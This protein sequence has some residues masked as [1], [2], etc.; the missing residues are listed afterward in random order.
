MNAKL[1]Q[2]NATH[3]LHH[4]TLA[5]LTQ[6][7]RWHLT[8]K[9]SCP[10][11]LGVLLVAISL[12]SYGSSRL[13]TFG[14]FGSDGGVRYVDNGKR[15][16]FVIAAR[17]SAR[18]PLLDM[19]L[20]NI[21]RWYGDTEA[22]IVI[23]DNHYINVTA[24]VNST[25]LVQQAVAA[26][27]LPAT[28]VHIVTNLDSN[29]WGYEFG[30]MRAVGRALR[31][32]SLASDAAEV[33]SDLVQQTIPYDFIIVMQHTMAL[34]APLDFRQAPASNIPTRGMP[35][36]RLDDR[37]SGVATGQPFR[38]FMDFP[39]NSYDNNEERRYALDM[40]TAITGRTELSVCPGVF[41]PNWLMSG[42]CAARFAA[43]GVFEKAKVT[44][45]LQQCASERLLPQLAQFLCGLPC[46]V[47]TSVDGSVTQYP[48]AFTL[49]INDP[50]APAMAGRHFLKKWGSMG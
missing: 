40:W 14:M 8:P 2:Q 13:T 6:A 49:A 12:I 22:D 31:W 41:G 44:V 19:T 30:A 24:Q 33:S 21:R 18:E 1:T 5:E 37:W 11:L 28:G 25:R 48:K 50:A 32:N 27:G 20:R 34:I 7:A 46:D 4:T 23:A 39:S 42:A 16:L 45:K 17:M 26:A 47:S 15:I 43:A 29:E 35:S 3:T 9:R 36:V 10:S 38:A